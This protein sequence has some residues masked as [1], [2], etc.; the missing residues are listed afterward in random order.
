MAL[1]PNI[2]KRSYPITERGILYFN[3]HRCELL[4]CVSSPNEMRT[5]TLYTCDCATKVRC[6]G[7]TSMTWVSVGTFTGESLIENCGFQVYWKFECYVLV[8][9]HSK[10][11]LYLVN[12]AGAKHT[13]TQI[14]SAVLYQI[15]HYPALGK[16]IL[17][18][19]GLLWLA[20]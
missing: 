20:K 17:S 9:H 19:S 12:W 2:A 18:V 14:W 13:R 3:S 7:K 6:N 15:H 16:L 8:K 11:K 4:K 5:T 10:Q 1:F